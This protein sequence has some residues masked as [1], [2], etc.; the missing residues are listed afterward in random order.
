MKDQPSGCGKVPDGVFSLYKYYFTFKQDECI[1]Y[2][3]H[4]LVDPL[5]KVS[6][7]EVS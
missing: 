7:M 1:A 5:V 2:Y 3:E 6:I 4:L